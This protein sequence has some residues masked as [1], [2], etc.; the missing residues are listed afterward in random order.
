M[1]PAPSQPG[2]LLQELTVLQV[3]LDL[4]STY[5]RKFPAAAKRAAREAVLPH[6][7]RPSIHDLPMLARPPAPKLPTGRL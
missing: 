6:A 3:Y 1:T 2:T 4:P 7:R 5:R